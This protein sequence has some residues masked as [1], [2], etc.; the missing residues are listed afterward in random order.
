MNVPLPIRAKLLVATLSVTMVFGFCLFYKLGSY[1]VGEIVFKAA[2]L[3]LGALIAYGG[4]FGN[5]QMQVLW[6]IGLALVSAELIFGLWISDIQ[7]SLRIWTVLAVII[8]LVG[9]YLLLLD[10]DVKVYRQNIKS[11]KN[12]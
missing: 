10:R 9:C 6:G 1:S 8:A 4:V 5:G 3:L 12:A 2:Y 7:G 11:K